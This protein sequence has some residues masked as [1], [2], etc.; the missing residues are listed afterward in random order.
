MKGLLWYAVPVIAIY[1]GW[2]AG[3]IISGVHGLR[4]KLAVLAIFE[5]T[6]VMYGSLAN[7][8]FKDDFV[9]FLLLVIGSNIF[10]ALGYVEASIRARRTTMSDN[11]M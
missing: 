5:V 7:S 2:A 4:S 11:E 10:C 1:G 6:V 8:F 9:G 3:A